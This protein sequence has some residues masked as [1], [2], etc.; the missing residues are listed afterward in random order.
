MDIELLSKA[1]KAFKKQEEAIAART[2]Y[3][4]RNAAID[5]NMMR[6]R[7]ERLAREAAKPRP[8]KIKNKKGKTL[9]PSPGREDSA[10]PTR[11]PNKEQN[12]SDRP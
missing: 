12:E 9:S 10:G 4:Q 11:R 1:E 7:A 5:A 3:E 8:N 6:L 2:E